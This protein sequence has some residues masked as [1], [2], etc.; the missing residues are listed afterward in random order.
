MDIFI[1]GEYPAPGLSPD[2]IKNAAISAPDGRSLKEVGVMPDGER[3]YFIPNLTIGLWTDRNRFN[4][5]KQ[6]NGD[7]KHERYDSAQA[8]RNDT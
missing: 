1:T 2:D 8:G 6:Q 3:I 7:F 4:N 5:I